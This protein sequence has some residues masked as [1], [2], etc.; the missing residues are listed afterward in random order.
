M[1]PIRAALVALVVFAG[2]RALAQDSEATVQVKSV[3]EIDGE[4]PEITLGDLI[5]ARGVSEKTL[6]TLRKIRLADT[7]APGE[8]RNFTDVGIEQVFRSHLASIEG[9][10]AETINLRVP[11]RVTVVRKS[12]RLRPM[13]VETALKQELSEICN[14]CSFEVTNLVLPAVQPT[15]GSGSKWQL[16]VR[17]ELPKGNFSIPL[18]V[19]NEDGTKRSYWITGSLVIRKNVPV[20]SRGMSAGERLQAEDFTLQ[21]KEVTFSTDVPPTREEIASSVLSRPI[22]PGQILWR[23]GLRREMAV[24]SGDAVKVTAGSDEWQ[25]SIDGI[26]QTSGYIGDLVKVKIPRT[27]KMISGLLTERGIVEVR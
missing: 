20:A 23:S 26:A 22:S 21:M 25:I 10:G 17:P 24:K 13:E 14:D 27:Q 2:I 1:S 4:T 15:I 19:A 8:S 18:E 9:A 16:R 11:A 5:V 3:V 12:F 6:D 7:P